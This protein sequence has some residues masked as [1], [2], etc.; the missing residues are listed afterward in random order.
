MNFK[1][2]FLFSIIFI[3]LNSCNEY[4]GSAPIQVLEETEKINNGDYHE[5]YLREISFLKTRE[6]SASTAGMLKV[7]GG[8][9]TMGGN[10]SQARQDEFP[11]HKEIIAP[12]WV[13]ETEVTNAQF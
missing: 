6:D 11:R 9:Y 2:Y 4:K 3:L 7:I 12:I 13:D 10:G 1:P 8:S 5:N